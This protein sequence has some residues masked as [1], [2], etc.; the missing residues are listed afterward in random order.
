MLVSAAGERELGQREAERVAATVGLVESPALTAYVESIG[1]RLGQQSPRHDVEYRVAIIDTPE[2]NAFALPGGYVYVSRG[3]LALV[4][5]ED[6]L[7][8]V[9]GH[10][11][12]HVAA[13]H[14]VQRLSRAAPLGVIT[15]L[16]AAL[17]GIVSPLIGNVVGSAG[18]LAQEIVLAPYDREQERQA[19]R[20]GQELAARAG[21]DPAAMARILDGLE[22]EERLTHGPERGSS[23][24][25]THP[26]TP[27]RVAD[28]TAYAA[29]LARP[30]Q[31]PIAASA[32]DFL[33][34]L[35]GLGVGPNAAAGVFDGSTFRHPD[36]DLVVVFPT[37]WKTRNSRRMAAAQAPDGNAVV[38]LE[39]VGPGDDPAVPVREL[40][41]ASGRDLLGQAEHLTVN[42]RLALNVVAGVRA[43][44]EPLTLDLT[45][46]ASAGQVYR[47][48]GAARPERFETMRPAFRQTAA[49][50][51]SLT[52][53]ER[54]GIRQTRLRIVRARTGETAAAVV[55]RT[56]TGWGAEMT[57]IANGIAV[58]DRV[59]AG[60]A[61]KVALDEPYG[62]SS[63]R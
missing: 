48:T 24:L 53:E 40:G 38:T 63:L 17:T 26:A 21:W 46:I 54:A 56:G 35:A 25:A 7:A 27:E 8:G 44:G 14:A 5:S 58:G 34:R 49:S 9:I 19:D 10:E 20:L 1:R 51:R 6:E 57:A 23:F 31:P 18:A 62:A 22:R 16:G 52:R 28:A 42:G 11:I 36:L 3:L 41:K 32:D 37:G 45:W 13:R 61:L 33:G 59:A 50:F 43:S 30:A 29:Q 4:D 15:G 12:G 55:E 60:R 2:P 47:I 39:S